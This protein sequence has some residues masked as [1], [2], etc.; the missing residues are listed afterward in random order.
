MIFAAEIV[1]GGVLPLVLLARRRFGS[2]PTCSSSRRSSPSL[3]VA[4]NRMNVVLF[5]MTF[6][7]RMPWVAPEVYTPSIVEWG[8]S[9]G[10]IA[11]TIF[12][13]GLAARLMPI[14]PKGDAAAARPMTY[15]ARRLAGGA[16]LPA[17][18]R[19]RRRAG[20]SGRGGDR[21]ADGGDPRLGRLRLTFTP[22]CRCS[23][24]PAS[25]STLGRRRPSVA[26]PTTR[27]ADAGTLR[28]SAGARVERFDAA[29]DPAGGLS[30]RLVC[31]RSRGCSAT[32]RGPSWLVICRPV[33]SAFDAWRDEERWLRS[34]CPTCGGAAGHG[35]AA[36]QG[37]GAHAEARLRPLPDALAI[38][39]NRLPVL[40][41]RTNIGSPSWRSKA[42]AGCASTTANAVRGISRPT[43]ARATRSVLLAD[44][45]SLHL[46]LLARD[47]G[48]SRKAAFALR[49]GSHPHAIALR[50]SAVGVE[51]DQTSRPV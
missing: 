4:Y 51:L 5:A 8:V 49:P 31:R 23:R 36:R 1:L 26:D 28:N 7:G 17:P 10:L 11:A 20:R 37:S 44:W 22:A 9:I 32:W 45:T 42:R 27:L 18:G 35:A 2:V 25:R 43:T 40:R 33:V 12:L 30:P 38:P 41:G 15:D 16:S 14:L 39:A 34:Y 6:R 48:L 47:R 46:D 19:A 13:F 3:G 21:R 29:A 24:A 50:R